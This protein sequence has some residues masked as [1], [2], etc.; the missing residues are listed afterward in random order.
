MKTDGLIFKINISLLNLDARKKEDQEEKQKQSIRQ[1]TREERKGLFFFN[2]C[3]MKIF[4]FMKNSL[5]AFIQKLLDGILRDPLNPW[6]YM[7]KG[8]PCVYLRKSSKLFILS[9]KESVKEVKNV[10]DIDVSFQLG[11]HAYSRAI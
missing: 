11:K 4:C 9:S 10:L 2:E 7:Q 1:E 5:E 6:K 3:Y 8:G